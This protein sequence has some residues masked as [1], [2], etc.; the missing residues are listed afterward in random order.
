MTRLGIAGIG[1]IGPGIDGWHDA[2]AVL[3]GVASFSAE[4]EVPTAAAAGLPANERRRVPPLTRMVLQCCEDTLSDCFAEYPAISSV[5]ASSCGDLG[6][7][8][9]I[10]RALA[11]PEKPVS[12]TLFHNSVHNSP[13]G[14]WSK[15]RGDR[16]GSI[17]ISAYDSSFVA[18]MLSA[19]GV[20]VCN[21]GPTL[22]VA[23]DAVP[24]HALAP[25]RKLRASFAVG[26]LLVD[27]P[28]RWSMSIRLCEKTL[29]TTLDDPALEAMRVG[30]PAARSLPLL[31]QLATYRTSRVV[32]PY[33]SDMSV[34][35][36]IESHAAR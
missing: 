19:A 29:C 33:L 9:Q 16:S 27:V 4:A 13:A 3:T 23:Y 5:F 21:A 30:N 36:D 18:G 2:A 25:F 1:V 8:D 34:V 11:R 10:L 24:P 26:L 15:V 6:V 20:V 14:Y 7:A 12:P 28:A 35:I 32:L 17:S 22:L 31:K